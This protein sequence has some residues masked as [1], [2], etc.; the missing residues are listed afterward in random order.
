MHDQTESSSRPSLRF[1]ENEKLSRVQEIVKVPYACTDA[2]QKDG[3]SP[4]MHIR[5]L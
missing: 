2:Q 1:A 4:I 3:T 5:R